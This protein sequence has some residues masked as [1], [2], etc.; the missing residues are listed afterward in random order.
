MLKAQKKISKKEL[1]HD[2]LLDSMNK[3]TSFYGDNKKAIQYSL[4]ALILLIVGVY[5]Y[6]Q[7]RNTKNEEA[8]AKLGSVYSFY[9]QNQYQLAIDGIP[10]RKI[11]GLKSIV[12]EYGGTDAGN[13]ARFYLANSYFQ[14]GKYDEALESFDDFDASEPYL[15]VSRLAGMASCYEAKKD[16]ERAAAGF[17]KA[18]SSFPKDVDAA[19]NLNNAAYNF[20]LSGKNDRALELFKKL[21]REY[22]TSQVAREADR[23]IQK[24]TA[25]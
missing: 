11:T 3:V 15:V 22:P 18:A 7:N 13:L 17:E 21:K 10:E 1:K 12:G 23:Y 6:T 20:M 16:Y 24:L 8:S 2:A 14:L 9:D 4:G 19:T 25:A 5:A